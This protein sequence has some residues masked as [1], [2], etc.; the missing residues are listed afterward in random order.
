M[1][2]IGVSGRDRSGKDTVAELLM[3]RGYFGYSFGD[4]VRAHAKERH[5]DK[6]DPISVRNLTETSNWLRTQYGADVILKEALAE[7]EKAQQAGGKYIGAVLFSVRAPIEV[8]FI[9]SQGGEMVWV[10]A[11]DEVRLDRR[12]ANIRSGEAKVTLQEMLA[13]EAQ[14]ND[15]QPG[16]P[17]EVQMDLNYIQSKATIVIENNGNDIEAFKKTVEKTLGLA[18]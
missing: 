8:D 2:I 17:K 6:A 1:K 13:Q 15:P 7:F 16:I 18:D 12:L 11:S 5:K 9:L 10:E 14:Q 3:E 4:A